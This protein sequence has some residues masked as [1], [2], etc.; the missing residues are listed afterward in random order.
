MT[1][2]MSLSNSGKNCKILEFESESFALTRKENLIKSC[3]VAMGKNTTSSGRTSFICSNR[4]SHWSKNDA[5]DSR[6]KIMAL[7]GLRN[8]YGTDFMWRWNAYL[9]SMRIAIQQERIHRRAEARR[10]RTEG[11]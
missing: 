11:A 9:F 3:L 2:K 5:S 4:G 1:G 10:K 6:E 7:S 8:V